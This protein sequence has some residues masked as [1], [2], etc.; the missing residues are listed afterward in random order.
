MLSAS[1]AQKP[2]M[3]VRLGQNVAQNRP[4]FWPPAA[5]CD[6]CDS[7]EPTPPA[8]E[9]AHHTSTAHITTL[10]GADQLSSQ[11]IESVPCRMKYS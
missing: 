10:M 2:T 5:N 9:Q 3:A 6:G 1:V 11:R 8:L 7:I 4:A